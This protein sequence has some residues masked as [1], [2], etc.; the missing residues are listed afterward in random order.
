M[1]KSA[2]ES[3]GEV[4][5]EEAHLVICDEESSIVEVIAVKDGGELV[6]AFPLP[7][8]VHGAAIE[9]AETMSLSPVWLD[10][11]T[12]GRLELKQLPEDL[13]EGVVEKTFGGKLTVSF[14]GRAGRKYLHFY[15]AVREDGKGD[16]EDLKRLALKP[17]ELAQVTQWVRVEGLFDHR[18]GD[19]IMEI[20][21]KL[22]S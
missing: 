12:A 4:M 3:L 7:M 10:N 15:R 8:N 5:E 17:G 6:D 14:L 21:G 13:F 20:L 9:V 16:L 22:S 11:T 19:V 1:S 2:L 18:S